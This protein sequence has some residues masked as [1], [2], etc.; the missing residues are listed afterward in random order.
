MKRMLP[1]L[2]A[3]VFSAG[4]AAKMERTTKVHRPDAENVAYHQY[5]NQRTAE[6]QQMGG[7]FKDPG[8]AAAR[9]AQDAEGRFGD[10]PPDVST[11]WSWG[12]GNAEAQSEFNDQLEKMARDRPR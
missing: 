3:V 11:T 8:M 12:N 10:L 1:L 9:A 2:L 6:L 4:C 5:V 7:P